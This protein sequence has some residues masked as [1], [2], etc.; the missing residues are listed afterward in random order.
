[1]Y[2]SES[3]RY[4]LVRSGS[5]RT[6]IFSRSCGPMRYRDAAASLACAAAAGCAVSSN[7][8]R[9]ETRRFMP[10]LRRPRQRN[11][12]LTGLAIEIRPLDAKR[13]R[14]FGHSPAVMLQ[15]GRDVVAFEAQPGFTQLAGRNEARGRAFEV[16]RRE[17][18][19]D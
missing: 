15:H 11:T 9:N 12:E 19:F 18:V 3:T 14:R 2:P 17:H 8:D 4:S 16:E 1:M 6:V 5:S 7:A 13:G 10:L